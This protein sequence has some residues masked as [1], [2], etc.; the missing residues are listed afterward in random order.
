M[1]N[2][3][4]A[5]M[6][7]SNYQSPTG[8]MNDQAQAGAHGDHAQMEQDITH[9]QD[10]NIPFNGA[11]NT[12]ATHGMPFNGAHNIHGASNIHAVHGTHAMHNLGRGYSSVPHSSRATPLA[13][14]VPPPGSR[15]LNI[16]TA[17]LHT[18][19]PEFLRP[20]VTRDIPLVNPIPKI[21]NW[22]N[23][24]NDYDTHSE[25]T[26]ADDQTH[27]RPSGGYFNPI[28]PHANTRVR[29]IKTPDQSVIRLAD[30]LDRSLQP[31][32]TNRRLQAKIDQLEDTLAAQNRRLAQL[33]ITPQRTER[34]RSSSGH[35][36]SLRPYPDMRAHH[37][38]PFM[39]RQQETDMTRQRILQNQ[40]L[41]LPKEATPQLSKLALADP[42]S[43]QVNNL[44]KD[45]ARKQFENHRTDIIIDA[46]QKISQ[47]IDSTPD[48]SEE[49]RAI[50]ETQAREKEQLQKEKE[51]LNKSQRLKSQYEVHLQMPELTPEE[52]R[53]YSDHLNPKTIKATIGTF[54]STQPHS[55]F[56]VTWQKILRHGNGRGFTEKDYIDILS[57]VLRGQA[58]SDLFD[59][60]NQGSGLQEILRYFAQIYTK[61]RT[62]ADSM[63]N[64]AAFSRLPNEPIEAC[65]CR[66]E[67][68]I[69][70]LKD[71]Y[72]P[73]AW[74]EIR[75]KQL[76]GVLKQVIHPKTRDH[77]NMV[78]LSHHKAGTFMDLNAM[79][80]LVET[81]ETAYGLIPNQ[82]Q[83]I[84][85][86]ITSALPINPSY[87]ADFQ[88]IQVNNS[89]PR[90]SELSINDQITQLKI[91]VGELQRSQSQQTYDRSRKR[92]RENR[93]IK[94]Y[95]KNPV[96]RTRSE[97]RESP[98]LME[99]RKIVQARRSL[100][101][102][103]DDQPEKKD[104]TKPSPVSSQ[105]YKAAPSKENS[106]NQKKP[107]SLKPSSQSKDITPSPFAFAPV[108]K[109]P[110]TTYPP[111]QDPPIRSRDSSPYWGDSQ[112][113]PYYNPV[114]TQ[115]QRNNSR[116]RSRSRSNSRSRSKSADRDNYNN[117]TIRYPHTTIKFQKY[118]KCIHSGCNDLHLVDENHPGG[119]ALQEEHLVYD[120]DEDEDALN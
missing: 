111:K 13:F 41:F 19:P 39:R 56:N 1:S 2:S 109:T 11:H 27:I 85:I 93:D 73:A 117:M 18:I 119:I 28:N 70:P 102:D 89:I 63:R 21:G 58:E 52:H 83:T 84:N 66:A 16:P 108:A 106:Q 62:I 104:S 100:S 40:R 69:T 44:Q 47:K 77:L 86:N 92:S 38:N 24:K 82:A 78:E 114:R 90:E 105:Q 81:H 37:E 32:S 45:N 53:T 76:I 115:Y 15:N 103:R 30:Q 72:D 96:K 55:D 91:L 98:V 42:I 71:L 75:G 43:S 95:K 12:H 4:R 14:N 107:T 112:Y 67:K 8:F 59:M 101:K 94:D 26:N 97:T 3:E 60:I 6:D 80:S 33:E 22:R 10:Q 120:D 88:P 110:S 5:S 61:R 48:L 51:M 23:T 7:R 50:L 113:V 87:S 34:G 54:D 68:A 46:L 49:L 31:D 36:Q 99:P 9:A 64:V 20:E 79:V 118:A 25:G 17:T 74:P 35:R 116:S 65:I 29:V 57:Y